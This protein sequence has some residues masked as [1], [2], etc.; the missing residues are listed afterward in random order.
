MA[1]PDVRNIDGMLTSLKYMKV[2]S[3]GPR[4]YYSPNETRIIDPLVM[5]VM[6][7]VNPTLLKKCLS[8]EMSTATMKRIYAAI[9]RYDRH[10]ISESGL[11]TKS[12]RY[13]DYILYKYMSIAP[14]QRHVFDS[15]CAELMNIK[16]TL[17]FLKVPRDSTTSPGLPGL[18]LGHKTKADDHLR[19]SEEAL[20]F[21]ESGA[22]TPYDWVVY[23]KAK[24][25]P[26]DKI[27]KGIRTDRKSVV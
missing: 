12:A 10:D 13:A 26:V 14:E 7:E 18:E 23:A 8:Y 11:D 3:K 15:R 5:K 25:N 21:Y 27:D 19:A 20:S 22:Y 24:E 4:P 2:L 6:A 17:H 16:D 1:P 9:C